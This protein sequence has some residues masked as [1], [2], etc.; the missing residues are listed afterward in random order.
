MDEETKVI[1]N[2][3]NKK[4]ESL[5][6]VKTYVCPLCKKEVK[7]LIEH[8]YCYFPE[9]TILICDNCNHRSYLEVNHPLLNPTKKDAELFRKKGKNA[10]KKSKKQKI[11]INEDKIRQHICQDKH[12]IESCEKCQIYPCDKMISNGDGKIVFSKEKYEKEFP[13][14]HDQEKFY[15]LCLLNEKKKRNEY[16]KANNPSLIDYDEE[17]QFTAED[18]KEYDSLIGLSLKIEG[19]TYVTDRTGIYKKIGNSIDKLIKCDDE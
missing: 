11:I 7:R 1:I 2:E 16:Y 9:K 6:L 19:I 14:P 10:K 5:N 15:R 4:I 8:H 12:S 13:L 3:L 17:L 18:Q